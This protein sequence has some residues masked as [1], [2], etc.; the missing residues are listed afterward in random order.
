MIQTALSMVVVVGVALLMGWRPEAGVAQWVA[1]GGVLALATLALT[2]LSVALG[3][4]T[5]SVEAASNLPM[6]LMLLP[7]LG[8]GFV[9][10]SSLPAGL[11][12]F[13]EHQP[14][15]PLIETIRGLLLG[16]SVG[17]DGPVAVAWCIAIA[18]AGYVWAM[19]LYERRSAA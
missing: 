15:T 17:W 4:V 6:P 14:F 13:A 8:S 19:W 16:A 5:K 9:P 3:L 1:V 10:T 11:R 2:W 18:I 7:F 12:W